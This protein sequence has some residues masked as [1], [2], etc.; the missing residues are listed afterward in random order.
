M[1]GTALGERSGNISA[2]LGRPCPRARVAHILL[3]Y[4]PLADWMPPRAARTAFPRPFVCMGGTILMEVDTPTSTSAAMQAAATPDTS[5]TLI[6]ST[7]PVQRGPDPGLS[8]CVTDVPGSSS[9]SGRSGARGRRGAR[10][11]VG[12]M[13]G[14][15][16]EG[17]GKRAAGGEAG[18]GGA[19]ARGSRGGPRGGARTPAERGLWYGQ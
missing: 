11:G 16:A 12:G 4:L 5:R 13:S 14:T 19:R 7:S 8:T 17:G 6:P 2:P 9:R 1:G 18:G 15:A 3:C 10:G